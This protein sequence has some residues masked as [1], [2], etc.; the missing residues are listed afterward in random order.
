MLGSK[1]QTQV[2]HN[3]GCFKATGVSV[4]GVTMLT[5]DLQVITLVIFMV[6]KAVNTH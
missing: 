5:G 3:S 2:L 1:L 6:T 4:L